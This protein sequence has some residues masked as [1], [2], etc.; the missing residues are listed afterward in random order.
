MLPVGASRAGRTFTVGPLIVANELEILKAQFVLWCE[1]F[2]ILG[3]RL[4]QRVDFSSGLLAYR[5]SIRTERQVAV[6][7]PTPPVSVTNGT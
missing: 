2:P 7:F 3:S 6:A 1:L 4:A 5:T